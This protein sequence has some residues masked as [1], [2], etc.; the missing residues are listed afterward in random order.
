M[1]KKILLGIIFLIGL[2]YLLWP[3]PTHTSNFSALPNSLKSEEP[4]D[5][6]QNPNN[7]AYFSQLRRK[8]VTNY[9]K[10]E[11]SYLKIFGITIPPIRTNHPPEEAFIY[12]RDQQPST[13]LEQYSY[14]LRDALFVNGFEPFSETG[15]PYGMGA[16]D[17]Y[18]N[19]QY[20]VSKTTLRYY[21][22]SVTSR[23]IVYLLIWVGIILLYKLSK[24][25]ISEK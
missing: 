1:G 2:T 12:I 23:I 15:K 11:F 21:G 19:E 7:A 18:I 5:T 24:K 13:Y 14:P 9:Y 17:I 20:F 3:G 8:G 4:G 16:T 10:N 25:A 22:S 6:Y